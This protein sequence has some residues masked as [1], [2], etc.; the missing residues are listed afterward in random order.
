MRKNNKLIVII[1]IIL[2]LAIIGAVFAYLFLA[3]DVFKSNKELFAKYFA[4]DLEKIESLVNLDTAK[5]YQKLNNQ[6]KYESNTNVK[7]IHSEGGEVSNPLN[8]LSMKVDFQKDD[9]QQYFY[10]NGQISYLNETYL[11]VELIKDEEQYGIRFPEAFKQ[12]VTIDQDEDIQSIADNLG[13]DASILETIIQIMNGNEEILSEEQI[14]TTK[15]K[16]LNILTTEISNGTFEKQKNAMITYNDVTTKTN[17]YTVSLTSEQ[18]GKILEEISEKTIEDIEVPTAKITVYE[19]NGQTIRTAIE[20]DE[21]KIIIENEQQ[22]GEIKTKISYSDLNNE[23]IIEYNFE[24]TKTNSDTQENIGII[25]NIMEGEATYEVTLFS[26]MQMTEDAIDL[27]IEISHKQDIT[28]ISLILENIVNIG[29]EFDKS[30]CLEENNFKSLSAIQDEAKRKQII[31]SL[32]QIV[33]QQSTGKILSL[34]GVLMLDEEQTGEQTGE[35]ITDE[36]PSQS[37]INNFNA[38]FEF[39]TGEEVSSEN[40]KV[41]LDIIKGNCNGHSIVTIEPSEETE[42]ENKTAITLYIQ[43]GATNDESMQ[44]VLKQIHNDKKYQ[45]LIT[46]K[47]SNGLIDYI[48]I[49]EI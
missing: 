41:L 15:D 17:A 45:V 44:E 7:L 2:I 8:N 49:T 42:T 31:D 24:I 25:A 33:V 46:Y 30:Q 9:E 20:L 34:V 48:T 27:D 21:N 12:F 5:V 43:E 19:Q 47:E 40:V 29:N 26:K 1:S 28:T 38:K 37:E 23:E 4:Q 18:V 14:Q 13:I 22:D 6:T 3:T 16:Y 36:G 39:Y 11:T 10:G 32:K 35:E